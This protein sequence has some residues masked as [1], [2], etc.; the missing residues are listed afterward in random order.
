MLCI[1]VN[2]LKPPL[3]L[4]LNDNI[5]HANGFFIL[6]IESG[7]VKSI[8]WILTNKTDGF[9]EGLLVEMNMLGLDSHFGLELDH[10]FDVFGQWFDD[11]SHILKDYCEEYFNL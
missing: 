10:L 5:N 9:S 4:V 8:L 11:F 3:C 2:G 6:L 7:D 1:D